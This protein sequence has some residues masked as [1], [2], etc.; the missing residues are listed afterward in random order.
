MNGRA[1]LLFLAWQ[2]KDLRRMAA[3]AYGF[4]C[5]QPTDGSPARADAHIT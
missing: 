1:V 2:T 5:S 4:H 3:F